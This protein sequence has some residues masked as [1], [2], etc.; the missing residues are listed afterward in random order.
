MSTKSSRFSRWR[1]MLMR[2]LCY[3]FYIGS[4]ANNDISI[5]L[6]VSPAKVSMSNSENDLPSVLKWLPNLPS[7]YSS[8]SLPLVLTVK[9]HGLSVLCCESWQITARL[10]SAQSI[11]LPPFC[12]K[13]STDC[14]SL[15]RA[16]RPCI[17]GIL[18]RTPRL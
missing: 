10:F 5:V 16:G 9:L 8:T 3:L 1:A 15:P 14:S 12:S 18:G 4:D 11:N 7:F 2:K 6:L 17:L 13:S